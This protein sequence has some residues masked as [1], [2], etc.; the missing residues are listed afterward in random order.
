LGPIKYSYYVF[1]L[2]RWSCLLNYVLISPF[3]FRGTYLVFQKNLQRSY[4]INPNVSNIVWNGSINLIESNLKTMYQK[5]QKSLGICLELP[6]KNLR[7]LLCYLESLCDHLKI[8]PTL[9]IYVNV[10]SPIK[11]I[12]FTIKSSERQCSIISKFHY[13]CLSHYISVYI[14]KRNVC[15]F[16]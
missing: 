2:K 15:H 16:F 9:Y 5:I 7:Q 3:R 13:K 1:H 10:S 11:Y 14:S 6:F 12:W 4:Y 8:I